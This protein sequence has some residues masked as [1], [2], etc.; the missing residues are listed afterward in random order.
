MDLASHLDQIRRQI[1]KSALKKYGDDLHKKTGI[2]PE[3]VVVALGVVLA[4]MLF[5]GIFPHAICDI[6]AYVFPFY[7]TLS[8]IESKKIKKNWCVVCN[9]V[10]TS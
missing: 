2:A 5:F 4:F 6:V 1:D 10:R 3:V 9:V 7:G 8:T